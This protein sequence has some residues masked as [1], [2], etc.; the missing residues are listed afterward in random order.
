MSPAPGFRYSALTP[1]AKKSTRKTS[2]RTKVA[3]RTA[4]GERIEA[5][6]KKKDANTA[7]TKK[8]AGPSTIDDVLDD[9]N[10]K[11]D[12]INGITRA[13]TCQQ[14]IEVISKNSSLTESDK[15]LLTQKLHELA[16]AS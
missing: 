15:Q 9:I 1:E 12:R 16:R 14:M 2:S 11:I 6:E 13:D 5:V 10:S 3:K 4:L 8:R 7:A